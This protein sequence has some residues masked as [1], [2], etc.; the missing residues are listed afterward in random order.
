[1]KVNKKTT[2]FF[3]IMPVMI[4]I[5][6]SSQP[7]LADDWTEVTPTGET[8]NTRY[9]HSM[10]EFGNDAYVFGGMDEAGIEFNDLW[11]F[12]KD[13]GEWVKHAPENDPPPPRKN[14]CAFPYSG[15]LYI[16]GG[17]SG[18]TCLD[19]LWCYDFD[20]QT[21]TQKEL[22]GDAL[23]DARTEATMTVIGDKAY[24]CGGRNPQTEKFFPF[25][26]ALNLNTFEF[27][28]QSP[29]MGGFRYGHS[30]VAP[31]Y[32]ELYILGGKGPE[33]YKTEHVVYHSDL[34]TSYVVE[35]KDKPY[36]P[37]FD[38]VMIRMFSIMLYKNLS[39]Y[40]FGGQ[41]PKDNPFGDLPKINTSYIA[42]DDTILCDMWR[43]NF[44]DSTVTQCADLPVALAQAAGVVLDDDFYIFGGMKADGTLSNALYKYVEEETHMQKKDQSPNAF[45]LYPNYPN[46]FNPSTTIQYTIPKADRVSLRIFNLQ[47]KQVHTLIDQHQSSGNFRISFNGSK[48]P[49]GVYFYKLETEGHTQIRKMLLIK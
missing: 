40:L 34:Q 27:Q 12:N 25:V 49:S 1:M 29:P 47:G 26:W 45:Y 32:Y 44:E 6:L 13:N 39:I 7:L 3:T 11:A 35:W 22:S 19:D 21:W 33:E 5:L 24:L 28:E 38:Q 14:H 9:G 10:T 48:L 23:P 17:T 15:K 30:T 8:P 4:C 43:L 37:S 42:E 41:S 46:P 31:G 16:Y 36:Q 18:S 2:L 20:T